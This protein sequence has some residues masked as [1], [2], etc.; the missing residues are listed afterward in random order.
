MID[1][2]SPTAPSATGT[3]AGLPPVSASVGQLRGE[4]GGAALHVGLDVQRDDVKV[5][6]R[7]HDPLHHAQAAARP[8]GVTAA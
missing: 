2:A 5:V 4:L 8:G 7:E 6:A 3:L 1:C